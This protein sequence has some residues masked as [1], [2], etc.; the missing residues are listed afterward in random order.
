MNNTLAESK[1]MLRQVVQRLVDESGVAT[2]F[3]ASGWL[4]E[5]INQPNPALGGEKPLAFLSSVS[6]RALVEKLLLSAQSGV[7]W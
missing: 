4:E 2:G 7:I 5:W 6:G 3:D 1:D